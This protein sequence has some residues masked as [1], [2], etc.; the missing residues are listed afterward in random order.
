MTVLW[1]S[2]RDREAELE[3]WFRQRS[4]TTQVL[5]KLEELLSLRR[6]RY[7]ATLEKNEDPEARGRAKECKE[8]LHLFAPHVTL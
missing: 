7:R 4:G 3:E 2:D 1:E 6:T 8:M 5:A